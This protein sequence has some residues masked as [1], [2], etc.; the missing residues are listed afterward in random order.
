MNCCKMIKNSV[1]E[2]NIFFK[3]AVWTLDIKENSYIINHNI[4]HIS[5]PT[6]KAIENINFIQLFCSLKKKQNAN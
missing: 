2:M 5:D 4:P 6:E 3:N 1:E